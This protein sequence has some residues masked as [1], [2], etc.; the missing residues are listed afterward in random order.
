M[1]RVGVGPTQIQDRIR[2]GSAFFL[3]QVAYA[4]KNLRDDILIETRLTWRRH[5]RIFPSDPAGRVGHASIFFRETGA[6]Q[7]V[8]RGVDRFLLVLGYARRSPKVAGLVLINFANYQPIG[9]LQCVDVFVG[10][11]ADHHSVHAERHHSLDLAVV[12]VFPDMRPGAVLA[13]LGQVVEGKSVFFGGR[14]AVHRLHQRHEKLRSVLVIIHR[15]P[16]GGFRGGG[17]NSF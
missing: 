11:R 10:V 17:R 9:L 14:V 2:K 5:R 8:N 12:H 13:G 6:G 16:R 7:T 15:I 4:Q 3:I 1:R